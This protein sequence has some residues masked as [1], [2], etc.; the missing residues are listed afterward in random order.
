MTDADAAKVEKVLKPLREALA[1]RTPDPADRLWLDQR[2]WPNAREAHGKISPNRI[3]FMIVRIGQ[4]SGAAALPVFA[5]AG[6]L[7]SGHAW[8]WLTV[9]VSLMVAVVVA[10]DHVYRP[11]IRWRAAYKSFH[12]FIDTAWLYLETPEPVEKPGDP[13]DKF[14]RSTETTIANQ[15]SEYLRDIANLNTDAAAVDGA[16]AARPA[17]RD[18]RGS[19]T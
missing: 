1:E 16:S 8:G 10:F 12:E 9:G 17:R 15:Q 6:T 7:T 3:W 2:W 18:A 14:L 5:T 11:G 4:V 19:E 13:F